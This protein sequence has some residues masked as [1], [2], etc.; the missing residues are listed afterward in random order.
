MSQTDILLVVIIALLVFIYKKLSLISNFL[1]PKP[2]PKS[3]GSSLQDKDPLFDDALEIIKIQDKVSASLLQRR[4][5]IGYARA[6][7]LLDQLE[8]YGYI[9]PAIGSHPRTVRKK[10]TQLVN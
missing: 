6:A 9:S 10:T 5:A 8:F 3:E 2:M 4:L 7:R 1:L